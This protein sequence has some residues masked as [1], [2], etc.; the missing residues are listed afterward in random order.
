M[1]GEH[2]TLSDLQFLPLTKERWPD[3]AEL[4]GERGACGGCWC[5][6]WRLKRSQFER[7]KGEAN[8]QA[9]KAIVEAGE[10]PGILAYAQGKPVA[11][12]SVAPREQYPVLGRSRIL[13]PVDETPVWS[14]VCFFVEKSHRNKGMSLRLLRAAVEYVK[15]Q[16]GRVVEGYPVEPKKKRMPP[17]FAWTGFASTFEKAGFVECLR[18]SET[19]PIM[20]FYIESGEN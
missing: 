9:M 11:W 5:M 14:V 17:A 12:C 2:E 8:K 20:R 19:R 3:F 15:Q 18:R 6:W 1:V 13:K 4:F 10:I 7:Q 16:G